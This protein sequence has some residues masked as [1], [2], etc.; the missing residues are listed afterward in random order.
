MHKAIKLATQTAIKTIQVWCLLHH[1]SK[2]CTILHGI[3]SFYIIQFHFI[4]KIP[5]HTKFKLHTYI[6]YKTLQLM[7]SLKN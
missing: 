2:Y 6:S 1:I 7:L 3:A 5:Q 4:F